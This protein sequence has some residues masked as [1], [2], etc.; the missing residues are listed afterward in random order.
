MKNAKWLS[1][2][3]N[4]TVKLIKFHLFKLDFE[5]RIS[6]KV[7]YNGDSKVG[8]MINKSMKT[9]M[10]GSISGVKFYTTEKKL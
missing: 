1:L 9:G 7:Y 3:Y 10:V 5:F 6:K 2:T 8:K 4:K